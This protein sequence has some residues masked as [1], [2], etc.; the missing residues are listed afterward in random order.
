[1][2]PSSGEGNKD[3]HL[4]WFPLSVVLGFAVGFWS[5]VG[6]IAVNQQWITW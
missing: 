2:V 1:M 6:A 4:D 3:Y 5:M